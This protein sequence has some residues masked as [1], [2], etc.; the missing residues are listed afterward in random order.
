MEFDITEDSK[1]VV[2]ASDG[3]WEFI[4]N[5]K[6]MQ[7]VNPYY[8]KNDPEGACSAL[9]KQATQFWEAVNKYYLIIFR[10]IV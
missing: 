9:I 4:D 5:A 10:R 8:A 3:I 6:A 7:I 2:I 1:Y